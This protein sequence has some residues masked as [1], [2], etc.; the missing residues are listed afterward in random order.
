MT[1]PGATIDWQA[2]TAWLATTAI[3]TTAIAATVI[4]LTQQAHRHRTRARLAT[5]VELWLKARQP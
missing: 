2:L 4:W 3:L 5:E 1:G